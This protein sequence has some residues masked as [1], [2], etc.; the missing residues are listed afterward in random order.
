MDENVARTV[1]VLRVI[2]GAMCAG[3]ALFAV[4]VLW[5]AFGA[6]PRPGN[7]PPEVF[8]VVN[9]AVFFSALGAHLLLPRLMAKSAEA[10][11]AS[12]QTSMIVRH[13]PLEGSAL[14]G[15]VI[16]FLAAP[17]GA[18]AARPALW[19]NALPAVFFWVMVA[20]NWPTEAAYE[21]FRLATWSPRSLP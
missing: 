13:A 4:I 11:P 18:L 7:P 19:L 12:W 21:D 17:T 9:A 16:C 14:L 6:P 8:S 3:I 2:L 15:L 1:G 20:R 5:F 10:T